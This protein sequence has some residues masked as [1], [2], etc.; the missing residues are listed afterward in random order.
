MNHELA[1]LSTFVFVFVQVAR[2][3]EGRQRAFL[4]FITMNI[5]AEKSL[6]LMRGRFVSSGL[7]FKFST[8]QCFFDKPNKLYLKSKKRGTSSDAWLRRQLSDPYVK[9]AQVEQY[10]CRSAFKLIEMDDKHKFL[11][12]GMNIIDCGAAP[13][14]WTQVLVKRCNSNLDD[15]SR[16]QGK[17]VS[18]DIK[19]FTEVEGA[20]ILPNSDF[21]SLETQKSVLKLL[22]PSGGID[23]VV[24][25]MAPSA[26][27]F[28]EMDHESIVKLSYSALRFSLKISKVGGFFLTKIWEGALR[29]KFEKDLQLY[30][31][32]VQVVKPKS[33]R[34]DSAEIFLLARDFKG[35]KTKCDST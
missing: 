27:G 16:A 2:T 7:L 22:N 19:D 28:Q 13:G 33:S 6:F 1:T 8:S 9:W 31:N 15:A 17:V 24:S 25:D 12:P 4:L 29:S 26:T 20:Q 21:T 23:G 14:S 3:Q 34:S 5:F 32:R 30:Y 10:R 18:V 11:F 35:L